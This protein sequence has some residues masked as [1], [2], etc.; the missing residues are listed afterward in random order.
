MNDDARSTTERADTGAEVPVLVSF[1]RPKTM[2]EHL[3]LA[4]REA[5]LDGR[6]GPDRT[7]TEIALA[8]QFGVSRTPVREVL[9]E[10]EHEGLLEPAG[11]RG[12][13]V[14]RISPQEIRELF[15]IRLALE[16]PIAARVAEAGVR[17]EDH[18]LLRSLIREQ[19]EA[20]ARRD[21]YRFLIADS[22]LH[23]NLA[24][25][26]GLPKVTEIIT[27]L[28]NLFQIVGLTAIQ[29]LGRL[30]EVV[31]EHLRILEAIERHDCRAAENAVRA[32]LRNTETIVMEQ[33][34]ADR[35]Y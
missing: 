6:I 9:Q 24:R 32:H 19:E 10:L 13:R 12:K 20:K 4:L 25:L 17:E 23:I 22:A 18:A 28:R 3:S 26:T 31:S 8:K 5:I 29:R 15:W 16:P 33:L 2:K 7:L 27:N 1:S 14:R 35:D 30:D 11:I 21:A 34:R